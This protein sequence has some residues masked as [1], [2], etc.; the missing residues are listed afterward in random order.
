MTTIAKIVP[1]KFTLSSYGRFS[2]ADLLHQLGD[3]DA[4]RVRLNPHPGT[5]TL[6]DLIAAN[7]SKEGAVC[8]WVDGT[9]V[10]KVMGFH[11]S[12]LETILIFEFEL[13]LRGNDIG[14]IT[15]PDGVMRILPDIGRAPDVS[16]I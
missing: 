10:E 11:E 7:E 3:V 5:A 14:M 12:T 15:G 6:K 16:F 9:L 13:Y 4:S 8:E 2:V 1:S